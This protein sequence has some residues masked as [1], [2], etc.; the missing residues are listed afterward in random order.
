MVASKLVN[1]L[2]VVDEYNVAVGSWAEETGRDGIA[3][4]LLLEEMSPSNIV[5]D[6]NTEMPPPRG[7]TSI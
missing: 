7:R 3:R 1:F 4:C 6:R 2:T 5:R